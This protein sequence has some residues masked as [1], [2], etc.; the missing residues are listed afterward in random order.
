[1]HNSQLNSVHD[2]LAINALS[3]TL[4]VAIVAVPDSPLRTVLGIPFVLFFPGYTLISALFPAKPDLG[5]IE[6]IAL[7]IGLSLA[8]VPLVGLGLNYTPWGIRLVPIMTSLF[9][10]TAL[11]SLMTLYRRQKLPTEQKLT[12]NFPV[13][14][15]KLS[16]MRRFDKPFVIIVIIALIMVGSLTAYLGTAPKVDDQFTEFYLLGANGTLADYPDNLTL[17]QSGIVICGITN[18]ENQNTTY[19]ITVT[20]KNQTLTTLDNIKV[21]NNGNWTQS[22]TFTPDKTGN[23]LKLE[24]QLYKEDSAESYRNLQLIVTVRPPQ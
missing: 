3:L 1:M 10:F 20:L 13:T 9:L 12:I 18:H 6:R 14:W 22:Y 23:Q 19:K 5:G 11:L 15:P 4:I 16:G 8:V 21:A 17:G 24:F 7:S 2:L